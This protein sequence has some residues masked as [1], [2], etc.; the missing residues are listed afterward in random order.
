[1]RYKIIVISVFLMAAAA[2]TAN[3]GIVTDQVIAP[4]VSANPC[5][6]QA[7]GVFEP[8]CDCCP[9][10]GWGCEPGFRCTVGPFQCCGQCVPN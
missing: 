6:P 4:G 2:T 10:Q 3:V 7:D 5:A 1:M 9:A 8:T